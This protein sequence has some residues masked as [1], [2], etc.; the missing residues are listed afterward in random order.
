LG[1]PLKRDLGEKP[2][3]ELKAAALI[4]PVFSKAS[5]ARKKKFLS[6]SLKSKEIGIPNE[7]YANVF[8]CKRVQPFV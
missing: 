7:N 3:R 5:W 2:R 8:I 1:D 4:H 6:N